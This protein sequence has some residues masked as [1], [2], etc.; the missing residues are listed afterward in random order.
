MNYS[1]L[2]SCSSSDENDC[3]ITNECK[4]IATRLINKMNLIN[5]KNNNNLN[6]MIDWDNIVS[7]TMPICF[8]NI[9]IICLLIPYIICEDIIGSTLIINLYSFL[10]T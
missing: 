1:E 4:E 8:K 10:G 9:G 3:E 6:W 2:V 7:I 5:F